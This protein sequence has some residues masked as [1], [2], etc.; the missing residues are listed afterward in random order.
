MIP[1]GFPPDIPSK[2]ALSDYFCR[3]SGADIVCS[4]LDYDSRR[5]I[6]VTFKDAATAFGGGPEEILEVFP[7]SAAAI[8]AELDHGP[9]DLT[10]LIVTLDG[11]VVSRS[12]DA[13]EDPTPGT[14]YASVDEYQ[15]PT[16]VLS[17]SIQIIRRNELVEVERLNPYTDIVVPACGL[18]CGGQEERLSFKYYQH[19]LEAQKVWNAI[20]IISRTMP[21][22]HRN[23][24]SH[25]VV[26]ETDPSPSPRVVGY[27]QPFVPGGDLLQTMDSRPLKLKWIKQLFNV[28]DD[29]HLRYGVVHNDL[30]PP[31][32]LVDPA[33]DN[34]LLIDFE[35][36]VKIGI[37]DWTE[38]ETRDQTSDLLMACDVHL[39]TVQDDMWRI[40]RLVHYLVTGGNAEVG[41][42]MKGPWVKERP[43][44]EL[45]SPIEQY[46][47]ALVD[48]LHQRKHSD[49][50]IT[51]YSQASEPLDYPDYMALPAGVT[52]HRRSGKPDDTTAVHWPMPTSPGGS[53][54]EGFPLG[55]S[56]CHPLHMGQIIPIDA[57]SGVDFLRYRAVQAG[58]S[59]LGW[60]RPSTAHLDPMRRLLASGRYAEEGSTQTETETKN[61]PAAKPPHVPFTLRDSDTA[62]TPTNSKPKHKKRSRRRQLFYPKRKRPAAK[63]P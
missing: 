2:L 7:N 18:T 51:K 12:T 35:F 13:A 15:I 55:F 54:L 14:H 38:Q 10:A 31:N 40:V 20:Q 63:R 32:M 4:V 34:L 19:R 52:T 39:T 5:W 62:T 46:H 29:L 61:Q 45:D 53:L 47:E 36:A 37:P 26:D 22:A 33:T 8:R 43:Q 11:Q 3:Y 42:I 1:I 30:R 49:M 59:V 57:T 58:N 60:E 21:H 27:T 56:R 17:S 16:G 25:L 48:W 23:P 41:K 9:P 50:K 6:Q 44:I 24:I 28:M